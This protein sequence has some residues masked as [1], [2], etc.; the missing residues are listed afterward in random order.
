MPSTE[1]RG[2]PPLP[3]EALVER[4]RAGG[5]AL[6][7]LSGGVDS[8]AVASLVEAALGPRAV[9]VTVASEAVA[10]REV[11]RARTVARAIGIRH[12]VVHA[13]PLARPA[14][15]AN[16]PDRCYHCRTVETGALRELGEREGVRQY[17]DGIHV[18]DLGD[19]RPGMRAL[20]EAGFVHP[21]LWGGWGK[22]EVRRFARARSL[23]NWD[24]P[25][26]ACL[27]SRVA[28]GEPISAELL[29]RIDRA[30][31]V[32]L[33]E[34]FRRVRVRVH[35]G[36]ARIEVDRAEVDRFEEPG[37]REAVTSRLRS[38]GFPTVTIDPRGYA[39]RDR[40]PV[41]P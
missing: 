11:E 27:S 17:L 33:A 30:E 39:G 1:V 34:G 37:L 7:A 14:Y 3:P 38:L 25:S 32:L 31:D 15:R 5:P 8:S 2:D 20:E 21:L 40:L 19:D 4:L 6:V 35:A 16:G 23:P 28:R 29:E 9:A 12:V 24:Q 18:D 10:T 41:V 13:N 26:D 36:A 22:V